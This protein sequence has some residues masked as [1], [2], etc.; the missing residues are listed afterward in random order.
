[1][2]NFSIFDQDYDFLPKFW[3]LTNISISDQDLD[4]KPQTFRFL[5]TILIFWQTFWVLANILILIFDHDFDFYRD[6]DFRPQFWFLTNFSILH[7]DFDFTPRFPFVARMSIL[8]KFSIF[9]PRFLIKILISDQKSRITKLQKKTIFNFD[10]AYIISLLF[11]VQL[12]QSICRKKIQKNGPKH[13]VYL[14]RL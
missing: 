8:I 7:Q 6:F 9:W 4:F 11:K 1:L 14:I 5:T 12:A 13:K 2:T 3:F 10:K